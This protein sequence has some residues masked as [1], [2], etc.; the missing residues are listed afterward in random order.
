MMIMHLRTNTV[1]DEKANPYT[2]PP[3]DS[4]VAIIITVELEIEIG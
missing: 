1:E 3:H 2:V 4:E